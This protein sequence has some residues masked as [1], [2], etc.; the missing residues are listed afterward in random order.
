MSFSIKDFCERAAETAE[1][2]LY[3]WS[4]GNRTEVD[5]LVQLPSEIVPIEVKS[6]TRVSGKSL[7]VYSKYY[8]PK[9]RVRLSMNNL[10]YN[11]GLLSCPLPLTDW[12]ID[13]F[14]LKDNI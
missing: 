13:K 11:D 6:E 14:I 9:H 8:E 7:A 2:M 5:F 1:D 4:S 10:K 3:Y 12:M